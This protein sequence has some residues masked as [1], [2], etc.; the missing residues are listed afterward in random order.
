MEKTIDENLQG[1]ALDVTPKN[2]NTK[3]LYLESCVRT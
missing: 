1:N 3:K 2:N